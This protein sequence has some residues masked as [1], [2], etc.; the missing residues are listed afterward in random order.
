M[1]G[2]VIDGV[3][4]NFWYRNIS[5]YIGK[6]ARFPAHGSSALVSTGLVC[7]LIIFLEPNTG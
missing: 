2:D 4:E 1:S 7:M 6:V 3:L 5:K